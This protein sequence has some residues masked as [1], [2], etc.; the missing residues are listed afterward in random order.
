MQINL[1]LNQAKEM[2]KTNFDSA[3]KIFNIAEISAKSLG[4]DLYILKSANEHA[5]FLFFKGYYPEALVKYKQVHEKS[6]QTQNQKY[7]YNSKVYIGTINMFLSNYNT[8]TLYMIESMKYFEEK[9]DNTAIA[10]IYLNLTY[11]QIEQ[12]DLLKAEE[13]AQLSYKYAET[14]NNEIY[15]CKA[16]LN[17]GEVYFLKKDFKT[18]L[19]FY[20]KSLSIAEKITNIDI[21]PTLWLNMGG[22]YSEL[23]IL[24][25]ALYYSEKIIHEKVNNDMTP[26]ILPKTYILLSDIHLLKNEL[27]K[28]VH[29]AK[30]ALILSDSLGIIQI[31]AL[32]SDR[33]SELYALIPDY[34]KAYEYKVFSTKINDS[35]FTSEK[36]RFQKELETVYESSKKQKE[37]DLLYKDFEISTLKNKRFK[38]MVWMSV[39]IALLTAFITILL[40]RQHKNKALNEKMDIEQ[41]LL[42]LQMNPHFIFNSVSAI[43]D[44]IICNNPLDASAY[45]A[46]FSQLMRNILLNSS[47]N[48]ITLQNEIATVNTYLKL[49]QL[50]IPDLLEYKIDLAENIEPEDIQVPPMLLQPFIENAVEHGILNN[51]NVIGI[52]HIR[53]YLSD[54]CLCM[55]CEDNGVGRSYLTNKKTPGHI[56][57][58]TAITEQRINLL[59]KVYKNRISFTIIDLF[60]HN[61]LPIGT[62]VRF[63]L[64]EL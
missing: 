20:K 33:L 44:F 23:N 61:K 21:R 18:A 30:E 24:D 62:K 53:Y 52:I 43:Q 57:M 12:K 58:A 16:L 27:S 22:V 64:P 32:A 41:K 37:L 31:K 4:D 51:N 34:K 46:D 55:E 49:Q 26:I 2:G 39:F 3:V 10:G 9:K 19:S 15:K 29:Y 7:L 13:Y 38:I 14:A 35:I 63:S 8:A 5:S 42:R 45:L 1:L 54:N 48:L 11:I 25:S 50:R 6:L 28:A 60:D 59:S 40:I 56:S 47:K 36:Y 17:I